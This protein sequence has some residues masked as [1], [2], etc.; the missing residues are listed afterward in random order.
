MIY[1]TGDTHGDFSRVEYFC[2][3]MQTTRDDI[4]IILG[5]AG[6]NFGSESRAKR[7]RQ[8]L[9][10]LPITLFCIHGN[11][12]YRPAG[13]PAYRLMP[14]HG[15]SVWVD[16]E[17]PFI[18]FAKDG[19]IYDLAGQKAIVLGGAYSVDKFYRLANKY[20]WYDDEQPSDE[21]KAYAEKQL[22]AAGWK[23]DVVLSH[24]V[25]LKYEPTEVFMSC[26]DQSQVDKSTEKW[27]DKI[28]E[29]LDYKAWY[30]GHYHTA[31]RIDKLRIMFEDFDVLPGKDEYYYSGE[32][33]GS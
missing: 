19:D 20:S 17:F 22:D 27:L 18:C 16:E 7:C 32:K 24:T 11:H 9:A 15:G 33:I 23:V 13:D 6:I 2:R 8:S 30:A 4:L 31:K 25:P 5:D 10:D 29:R 14:W 3:R 26:I 21:I 1:L 12:E 28:E